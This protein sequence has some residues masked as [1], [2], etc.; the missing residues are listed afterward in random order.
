MDT[1]DLVS[2]VGRRLDRLVDAGRLDVANEA[3]LWA[4]I[5]TLARAAIADKTRVL[6]RLRRVEGPDS[7]WARGFLSRCQSA[8]AD[9][10]PFD[11][12]IATAM[13]ALVEEEDRRVLALWLAGWNHAQIAAEF[14]C[15]PNAIRQRWHRIRQRLEVALAA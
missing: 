10:D 4:L 3:Q 15:T 2:T 1:A 9:P 5:N 8:P 14:D 13:E 12:T 7:Q 6:A 11:G